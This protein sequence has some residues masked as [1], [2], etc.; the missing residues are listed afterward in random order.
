MPQRR[1]SLSMISRT[2]P[3]AG[4]AHG[5]NLRCTTFLRGAFLFS[6]LTTDA[7]A[8]GAVVASSASAR[9]ATAKARGMATAASATVRIV[10][11]ISFRRNSMS[12]PPVDGRAQASGQEVR[13]LQAHPTGVEARAV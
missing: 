12:E 8:V 13:R 2:W 9:G 11:G 10:I 5:R 3:G 1:A 6:T 7:V 4:W